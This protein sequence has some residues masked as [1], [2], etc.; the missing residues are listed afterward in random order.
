MIESGRRDNND[1][2]FM[3]GSIDIA[4]TTAA[5]IQKHHQ[6]GRRLS[7]LMARAR[8]FKEMTALLADDGALIGH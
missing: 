2:M 4:D 1:A 6:N 7:V 3:R 5:G 8:S